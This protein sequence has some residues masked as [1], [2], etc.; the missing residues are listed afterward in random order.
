MFP[1]TL[2]ILILLHLKLSPPQEAGN[3]PAPALLFNFEK[4]AAPAGTGVY[5][6]S[7]CQC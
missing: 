2:F 1:D 3:L 5:K 4:E 7:V 6:K